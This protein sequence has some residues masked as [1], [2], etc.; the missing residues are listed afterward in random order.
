MARH[1]Q[2]EHIFHG[3]SEESLIGQVCEFATVVT[4]TN[5]TFT[6]CAHLYRDAEL[7]PSARLSV[8]LVLRVSAF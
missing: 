6:L 2:P 4:M 5:L 8:S 1:A 7:A 3:F